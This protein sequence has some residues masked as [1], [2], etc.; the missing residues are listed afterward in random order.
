MTWT[1]AKNDCEKRGGYLATITSKEEQTFILELIKKVKKELYF[2]VGGYREGKIWKWVTSED[3]TYKNWA[4]G[5]PDN[6]GGKEDKMMLYKNGRWN[7][8]PNNGNL[9]FN[10]GYICEW[11]AD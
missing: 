5:Q 9:D 8:L 3:F 11:D 2:W 1:N 7:D 4:D 6:Y 10:L